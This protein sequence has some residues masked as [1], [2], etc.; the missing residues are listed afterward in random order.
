MLYHLLSIILTKT[1]KCNAFCWGD[2][3]E[4]GIS[5]CGWRECKLVQALRRN[6][7]NTE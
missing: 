2:C 4:T 6:T 7:G 5:T 1:H 3:G